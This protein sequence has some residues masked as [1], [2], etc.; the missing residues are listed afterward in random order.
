[1]KRNIKLIIEYDGTRYSGWQFQPNGI[2]IQDTLQKAIEKITGTHSPVTGSGRTD[3]GVHA[4]AQVANFRTATKLSCTDLRRAL[5]AVL[6]SDIGVHLVSEAAADFNACRSA[7]RKTYRYCLHV[8]PDKPVIGRHFVATTKYTLK[9]AP[10]R[11]AAA[12]IVGRHDF[13]CFCSEYDPKKDTRRTIYDLSI[14]QSGNVL[15]LEITAN[16]FLYNMV[17]AIVGTLIDVGRG[18]MAPEDV[19]TLVAGAPREDAGPTAPAS[20]LMLVSVVY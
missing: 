17:R 16:G 18:K 1:M 2:T 9:T 14:T 5:N 12:F 15:T 13:R 3:A 6:P 19:K 11:K 4:L 10:M 8:G 20:G 7:K